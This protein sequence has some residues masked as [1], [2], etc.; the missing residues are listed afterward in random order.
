LY[1]LGTYHTH[2]KNLLHVVSNSNFFNVELWHQR[3]GHPIVKKLKVM[4]ED[5]ILH[6]LQIKAPNF[7]FFLYKSC[8]EGKQSCEKFP[9]QRGHCTTDLLEIVQLDL[10]GPIQTFSHGDA[11]YFV[12]FI[13]DYSR[14]C[15]VTFLK[16]KEELLDA[17]KT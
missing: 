11:K 14:K 13:D 8:L 4:Y 2:Y 12:T 5:G 3:L 15:E 16:A 1:E 7:E 17:L 6:R 9:T 10:C